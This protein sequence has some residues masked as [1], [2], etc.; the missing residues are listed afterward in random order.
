MDKALIESVSSRFAL[1][2]VLAV[3]GAA[4]GT[5]GGGAVV[6][7]E[8]GTFQIRRRSAEHS[9]P[10]QIRF[11]HALLAELVTA[12]FPTAAPLARP[13]G[14]TVAVLAGATF[15]VYPWIEGAPF[16]RGSEAQLG[17]LGGMLASF[18][19]ITR[20]LTRRKV[21]QQREDDPARLLRELD[22]HLP[23]ADREKHR[24]PLEHVRAELRRLQGAL[25]RDVYGKLDQ[26]VIHGDLHPGNVKF[27]RD[28]LVG[29]F[30]FDWAN[31]QERIRDVGDGILFFAS[32]RQA[33]L[34]GDDIWSL[35][36][37]GRLQA[38]WAGCFLDAYQARSRLT[39]TE[40]DALA[41]VMAARWLQIRIRGMRK[42]PADRRAEFLFRN[43]LLE[44]LAHIGDFCP[45]D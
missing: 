40:K 27:R 24:G 3:R 37:G 20:N 16:H 13:D 19:A 33:D 8:R 9:R 17:E 29:L 31:R 18:H 21:G 1:G 22:D 14:R 39:R 41:P 38:H 43:D 6:T 25:E 5:A 42:V 4:G 26:A 12:G 11:E 34:D 30:D 7:C 32:A 10:E 45:T 36:A 35:T 2:T 15:E 44:V 28:T 23:R